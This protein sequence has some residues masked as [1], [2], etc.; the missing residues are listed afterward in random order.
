MLRSSDPGSVHA[1]VPTMYDEGDT[2]SYKVSSA[3]AC[4]RASR[5]T[6]ATGGDFLRADRSYARLSQEEVRMMQDRWVASG[7]R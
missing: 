2:A 6:Y 4:E 5:E 7:G 3:L 1:S